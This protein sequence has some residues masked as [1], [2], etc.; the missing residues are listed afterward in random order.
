MTSEGVPHPNV[1]IVDD[2]ADF[3]ELLVDLL[4][5][6]GYGVECATNGQEALDRLHQGPR[7][8]LILLDLGLPV[9]DGRECMRQKQNSALASIPVVIMSG[10][11]DTMEAALALGA[12]GYLQ[13]P[14]GLGSL[15][16]TI[17]R[18]C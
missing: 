3:R 16:A 5:G 2:E 6:A 7:P 18:Y 9:L 4:E 10:G 14:F 1:L 15:L 17:A 11:G 12:V 8:C 13:K